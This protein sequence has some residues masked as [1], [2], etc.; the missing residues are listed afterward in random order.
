[1]LTRGDER[2]KFPTWPPI[3]CLLTTGLLI[4]ILLRLQALHQAIHIA[5]LVVR[6]SCPRQL[7]FLCRVVKLALRAVHPSQSR[8]HE[9]LVGMFLRIF[10]EDRERF[11]TALFSLQPA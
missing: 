8:M 4:N 9:P 2:D 1:M 3:L 5:L 7:H 11:F 6:S 10:A